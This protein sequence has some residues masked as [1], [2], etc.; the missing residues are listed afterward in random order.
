MSEP[1]RRRP[2]TSDRLAAERLDQ[3]LAKRRRW[4]TQRRMDP[5]SF[6]SFAER[7]A[8]FMGTARFLVWM[9]LFVIVWIADWV[10]NSSLRC[11][12]SLC[13]ARNG[14]WTTMSACWPVDQSAAKKMIAGRLS[15][16]RRPTTAT[17]ASAMPAAMIV[18]RPRRSDAPQGVQSSAPQGELTLASSATPSRTSGPGRGSGCAWP[19]TSRSAPCSTSWAALNLILCERR[20]AA[21]ACS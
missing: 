10:A 13:S 5:E 17:M 19:T 21:A 4:V 1:A 20:T 18:R 2:A 6:G 9:T 8:R 16:R 3:P 14:A 11:S 12:G 7:F 15:T